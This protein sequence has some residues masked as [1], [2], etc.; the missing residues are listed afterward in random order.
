M[1]GV[2]KRAWIPL[3]LVVVLAVSG[4]VVSRLHKMFASQ[5]LNANAVGNVVDNVIDHDG[6]DQLFRP[7][8]E[9]ASDHRAAAVVDH[10][11]DD[12]ARSQRQPD[13]AGR[14]QPDWMPRHRERNRP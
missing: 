1:T 9:R 4:L 5:D 10:V 8:C 7:G 2:L 6:A 3:V 14:H 12:V 13:G 11:V